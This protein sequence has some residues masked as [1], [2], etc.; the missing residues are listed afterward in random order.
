VKLYKRAVITKCKIF[1][2]EEM[3]LT[4]GYKSSLE[5]FEVLGIC[6]NN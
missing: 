5:A 1:T 2:G 3:F 4:R 6:G